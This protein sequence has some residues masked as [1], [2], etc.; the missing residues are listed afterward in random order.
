MNIQ[1]NT[2]KNIDWCLCI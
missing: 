1:L 2:K